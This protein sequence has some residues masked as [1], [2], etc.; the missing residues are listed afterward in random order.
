M[1]MEQT[2]NLS[3]E[4]L[5]KQKQKVKSMEKDYNSLTKQMLALEE[6]NNEKNRD[7]KKQYDEMTQKWHQLNAL[8]G[9]NTL[10]TYPPTQHHHA[11]P[12]VGVVQVHSKNK[13]NHFFFQ[14]KFKVN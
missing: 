8:K 11:S 4:E 2:V 9:S 5:E 3:V 12:R 10:C 1:H 7:I 13:N 6:R 14:T